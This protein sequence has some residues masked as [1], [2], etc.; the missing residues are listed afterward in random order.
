MK[1]FFRWTLA[2]AVFAAVMPWNG[3]ASAQ[4]YGMAS[5]QG[6]EEK[7]SVLTIKSDGS[8][9]FT[10]ETVESRTAAEQRVRTMERYQ[11][12]SEGEGETPPEADLSSTNEA[13]GPQ[14]FTDEELTKKITGTINERAEER[15]A[16]SGQKFNVDVKKDKVITTTTRLFSSIEAML[17]ESYTI[18]SQGGVVF[19]NARFETDTNGLLR[20]T[21]TPRSGMERYLKSTR[22]TWKLSGAK[23]EL[24]LV[25]PGKVVAS[26]FPATETNATWLA[27]DAR[28][29]ETFDVVAK[30]YAAPTVITAELGGL[31][32]DQPLE[33]KKLYRASR[34]RVVASDDLPITDAGPGFVAEAQSITTTMF[35]VFPGGENYFKQNGSSYGAQTGTVVNVKLFAPRGR[36]LQSVSDVRVLTAV[37][38]KG[39]SVVRES[40]DDENSSDYRSSGSPDASSLAIQLHLQLPSPDAQSIAEVSGE[41][42]ATSVGTW[43]EITLT[44]LQE[45]ATNELDLAAVLPGAKL[46]I[47]K[48]SAKNTQ[49]NIQAT[50]KGPRTV[51]GLDIRAKIPGNDRF[52]SNFSERNFSTKGGESTRTVAIQGYSFGSEDA[53]GQESVVLMVRMPEDLRRERIKFNLKALDLL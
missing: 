27:I 44:H 37:D 4:V 43:K 34:Q 24:K 3:A 13:A 16:D 17:K 48:F 39:R 40:K 33:S 8:C 6:G 36:T 18:W 9:L 42:V 7:H 2:S 23:S 47:T 45:N 15:A 28:H 49:L 22:S 51:R 20:V 50:L 14:P 5:S 11:K 41:V 46:I 53:S 25:F 1:L 29:D 19:D 21:F 52:N 35:Q 10:M 31:K 12:M 38:D 30:L 26:G 32:L